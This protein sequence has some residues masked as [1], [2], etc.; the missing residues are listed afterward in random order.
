[1]DMKDL[2]VRIGT[3]KKWGISIGGG[4][5]FMWYE[6]RGSALDLYLLWDRA[7]YWLEAFKVDMGVVIQL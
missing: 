5:F 7:I 3:E 2:T 4:W 1:M 6:R